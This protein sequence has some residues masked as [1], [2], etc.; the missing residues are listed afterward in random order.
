MVYVSEGMTVSADGVQVGR[1][2]QQLPAG[3]L[4]VIGN[5]HGE[6]EPLESLMTKLGYDSAGRHPHAR[7]LDFVGDL[8]DRGPDS[9]GVIRLVK[10]LID[11]GRAQ[12][13]CGNHTS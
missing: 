13:I 9:P 11:S 6:L 1:L 5:V 10:A 4:D 2:I 8:C 3:P 12:A 7:R